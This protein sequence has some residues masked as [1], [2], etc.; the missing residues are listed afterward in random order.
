MK[1]TNTCP[2]PRTTTASQTL[3]YAQLVQLH[4]QIN[5]VFGKVMTTIT[6][7]NY[8][9][10]AIKTYSIVEI[11]IRMKRIQLDI[12]TVIGKYIILR[13]YVSWEYKSDKN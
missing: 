1:H 2:C 9:S 3:L 13:A 11:S 8:E 10:N 4:L 12:K 6:P 7:A 5:H